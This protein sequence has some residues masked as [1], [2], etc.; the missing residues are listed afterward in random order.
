MSD[1]N[2]KKLEQEHIEN[3]NEQ[4]KQEVKSGVD[5]SIGVFRFIGDIFE[6]YLPQVVGLFVRMSGGS[7]KSKVDPENKEKRYP[8]K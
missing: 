2:F 4:K 8:N 1:N 6:L 5:S 7:V 3:F